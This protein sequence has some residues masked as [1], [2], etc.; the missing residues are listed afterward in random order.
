MLLRALAI[1]LSLLM[2]GL[3]GLAIWPRLEQER[4]EVLDL[5]TG[6]D[7]VLAPQGMV[8]SEVT[9]LGDDLQTIETQDVVP[10]E[11][12][13]SPP[14]PTVTPQQL[15]D[16]AGYT[17]NEKTPEVTAAPEQRPKPQRPTDTPT[18]QLPDVVASEKSTVEQE[19]GA[20]TVPALGQIQEP[21]V[22]KADEPPTLDRIEE[23]TVASA[24]EAPEPNQLENPKVAQAEPSAP[25]QIRKATVAKADL[26]PPD[27]LREPKVNEADEPPPDAP[28]EEQEPA[29]K[30]VLAQPEQVAIVTEQSSGEE[31]TGGDARIVGMYLGKINARVQRSKV[32]PH[33]RQTGSVVLKFTI[34]TDGSLLSKQIASSSGSRVLDNAALAAIDRAAPF[35]AIPE[36]VSTKPMVFTQLFRFVVR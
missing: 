7:I 28:L 24:H 33:S 36:K 15:H 2:H 5:G 18:E 32:N 22:V 13:R 35:P 3:V 12:Q 30:E 19:I 10:I 16:V 34:G 6:P 23:P 8:M 11:Q 25:D 20:A 21:K 14:A 4:L 1:F 17:E 31:K 27:E 26:P 9:N 29:A